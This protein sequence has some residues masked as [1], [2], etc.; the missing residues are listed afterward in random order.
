MIVHVED[1]ARAL[2]VIRAS[3]LA[4]AMKLIASIDE[5]P[6]DKLGIY[7]GEEVVDSN[8]LMGV[9]GVDEE[10]LKEMARGHGNSRVLGKYWMRR[11]GEANYVLQLGKKAETS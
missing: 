5:L 7:E 10:E 2:D 8:R 3:E 4:R 9:L 6:I 11:L 1:V